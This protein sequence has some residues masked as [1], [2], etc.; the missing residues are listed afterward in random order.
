MEHLTAKPTDDKGVHDHCE[1]C[2]RQPWLESL[3]QKQIRRHQE[4]LLISKSP[5]AAVGLIRL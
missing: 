2:I 3:T 4:A 1:D 5:G